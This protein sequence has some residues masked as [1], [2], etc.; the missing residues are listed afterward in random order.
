VWKTNTLL[1]EGDD[2]MK[3][4]VII[5][6]FLALGVSSFAEQ[7]EGLSIPETILNNADSEW[8]DI[9]SEE[10]YAMLSE[11]HV[12]KSSLKLVCEI[13]ADEDFPEQPHEAARMVF[14]AVKQF[15]VDLKRGK[16][17]V[18]VKARIRQ[19]WNLKIK[20]ELKVS[21]SKENNAKNKL[22]KS[23]EGQKVKPVH[24]KKVKEK[25]DKEEKEKKEKKEK[26]EKK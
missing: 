20:S 22:E 5:I 18:I 26:E 4:A 19:H 9:F 8:I 13:L 14:N 15:D 2:I 21:I 24:I 25:K 10:L 16:A 23:S 11:A 12:H 17:M 1:R 7:Q 6:I 3:K